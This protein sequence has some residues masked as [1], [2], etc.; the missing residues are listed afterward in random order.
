MSNSELAGRCRDTAQALREACEWVDDRANA[1]LVGPERKLVLKQLRRGEARAQRLSEA[2]TRPMCIGVYGPSQAGK[3]YLVSVLAKPREGRLIAALDGIE[4]G[5][6]FIA[7]INP[8]G[9]KEATGLVTRF[10]MRR[11][12]CPAG[13]PVKLRLL[14]EADVIRILA[15]AFFLDGD[16]TEADPDPEQI[17]ALLGSMRAR[18]GV[19]GP[20][21]ALPTEAVWEIQ[22]YIEH[23][24]NKFSYAKALSGF[25]EEA[26]E[27]APLLPPQDRAGLFSVLWGGYA[28]FTELYLA[29]V[30]ALEQLGHPREAFA[31]IE[32]LRPRESSIIDVATLDGLEAPQNAEKIA[33]QSDQGRAVSLP[34]PIVT[35]LT[36]ELV[37]PMAQQPW[38]IFEHSD[39]LDFPGVRERRT[40]KGPLESYFRNSEA[41]LKNLFLRG[42]VAFLFERYVAEQELTSMLLCV[43]PSNVEVAADLSSGVEDWIRATQGASPEERAKVD[44][45]LF[46]VLTKFDMHLTDKAGAGESHQRFENRITASLHAPFGNMRDSWPLNWTPDQPFRNCFWLR[47][48]NY[49]AEA[50]I[51]YDA[52]GREVDY[53]DHKRARI[54]ELKAGCLASPLVRTHMLNP[55]EAWEAAMALND[56]G[57]EYLVENLTPISRPEIKA[58]QIAARHQELCQ[59]MAR[60]MLPFYSDD[61]VAKRLEERRAVAGQIV[62]AINDAFDRR[63]FGRLI[64]GLGVD[65]DAIAAQLDQPSETVMIIA[66]E[67]ASGPAE[68]AR[69]GGDAANAGRPARARPGA[70][71][72]APGAAGDARVGSAQAGSALEDGPRLM[73]REAYQAETAILVWLAAMRSFSERPDI[74][75]HLHMHA[76]DVAEIV[77]ELGAA[78]RRIGLLETLAAELA[79]WNFG[80][81][82]DGQTAAAALAAANRINRHVERLAVDE[83]APEERPV[84]PSASGSRIAFAASPDRSSAQDLPE[85]PERRDEHYLEDW[86]FAL[87]RMFED[88]ARQENGGRVDPE[89]NARLGGILERF[90][91]Q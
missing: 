48:P 60:L 78:S 49:P 27:L 54:G 53:L 2:A 64:E 31:A 58:R 11:D 79:R 67:G 28:P 84:V 17:R 13:F 83:M 82:S 29:L 62:E 88:N 5:M 6:D 71:A 91:A 56:G 14:S 90:A 68:R 7:E 43:P 76:G 63:R 24:F 19:P 74:E 1:D 50:V 86:T 26:A 45:M 4:G 33:L 15:N 77:G 3:S 52:Q 20:V 12:A 22:D 57:V 85:E 72:P 80:S 65:P 47:N 73:T 38:P 23:T 87:Y 9:D 18:C 36:A 35:A 40:A 10:T 34:R 70:P 75:T 55:A 61:D 69:P 89:Q 51:Q 8:E 59:N 21:A 41:P 25:W 42:K 32:A 44:T 16:M 37:L 66:A 81:R 39:L 46:L 30:A